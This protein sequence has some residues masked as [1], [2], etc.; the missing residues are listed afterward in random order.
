MRIVLVGILLP[1]LSTAS[2]LGRTVTWTLNGVTFNDG[3]S[4]SGSFEFDHAIQTVVDWDISVSGGDESTFPPFTYSPATGK[5]GFH[6][7][8]D[9]YS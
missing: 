4:A 8:G 5:L 9:S 2:L 1:I 7:H 6:F 3:A